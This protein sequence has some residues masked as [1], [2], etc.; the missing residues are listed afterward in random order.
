MDLCKMYKKEV[1]SV[2]RPASAMSVETG[3]IELAEHMT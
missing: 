3:I 2:N 1:S